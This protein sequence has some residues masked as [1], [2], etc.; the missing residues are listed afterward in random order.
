MKAKINKINRKEMKLSM[1][2]IKRNGS[3]EE[4]DKEKIRVAIRK[5]LVETKECKNSQVIALSRL[6]ADDVCEEIDDEYIGI[7]DIQDLVEFKLMER[8][9]RN[10]AKA[11]ILYRD[12]KRRIREE[13]SRLYDESQKQIKNIMEMKNIENA[14]ANVDE[15]SFSGKNAKITSYFLKEY[16]LN[17]L[18]DKEVAKAH[19]E[20]ICR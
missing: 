2:V 18:I 8:G 20:D 7:E 4:F 19:R 10:T 6:V 12:N 14:N 11:Y 17:N 13:Q 5:A 3:I 9:L 15:G 16:A 1:F